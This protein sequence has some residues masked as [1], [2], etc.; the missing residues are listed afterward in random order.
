VVLKD[1]QGGF[2]GA[3]TSLSDVTAET[4][5]EEALRRLGGHP[6]R[7][8][9]RHHPPGCA[10][11]RI[12]AWTPAEERLYGWS[13][14]EALAMNIREILPMNKRADANT[15]LKMLWSGERIDP[16]ETRCIAKDGQIVAVHLKVSGLL[17]ATGKPYAVATTK[18]QI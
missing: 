6:A 16:F 5:S 10:Q 18:K 7:R 2:A 13:E 14:A 8:Q 17:D 11:G 1:A 12:L 9:R 3:V 15:V 4:R